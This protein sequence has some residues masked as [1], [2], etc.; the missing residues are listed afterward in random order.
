MNISRFV[1]RLPGTLRQTERTLGKVDRLGRR[2]GPALTSLRPAIRKL[3]TANRE[4]LP[5]VREA[6]PILKNQ[7][8]PF[9]RIAQ[10]FT[11]DLGQAARGLHRGAPELTTTLLELNRLFNIGAHNPG[12]AQGL[13]GNL[14]QDRA[15][16]EGYLYW[17]AWV[18]Q[19]TTSLFS[20][21]DA[22]GPFRRFNLLNL[23]CSSLTA[24][25]VPAPVANLLGTA[26]VCVPA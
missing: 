9:T 15:R 21:S 22:Q 14:A 25:G 7:I 5:L 23:N 11:R 17:L 3:D 20:T 12:G 19:V 13:T 8:R 2:M 16:D 18:S 1:E 10:P 26:G 4:V 6:T 24:G